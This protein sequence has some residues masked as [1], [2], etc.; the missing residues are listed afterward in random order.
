MITQLTAT[1]HEM[2]VGAEQVTLAMF[3][4]LDEIEPVSIEPFGRVRD[5]RDGADDATVCVVGRHVED[6]S[7]CRAR[8]T[9]AAGS[10]PHVGAATTEI[11]HGPNP[12]ACVDTDQRYARALVEGRPVYFC[13]KHSTRV[14]YEPE[15]PPGT[16]RAVSPEAREA[17]TARAL[18]EI[19]EF[20]ARAATYSSWLVLPLVVL[21]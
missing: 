10:L 6:G 7:L 3:R 20:D 11:E 8:L 15:L 16:C 5:P 14:R 4:Q 21:A 19:A 18:G 2:R 9:E 1:L 12:S 13:W 17:L